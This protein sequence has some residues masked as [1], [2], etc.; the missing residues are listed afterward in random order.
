MGLPEDEAAAH[1]SGAVPLRSGG[2]SSHGGLGRV[3]RL[4]VV[5]FWTVLR[6][7][8]DELVVIRSVRWRCGRR[9]AAGPAWHLGLRLDA[10]R[11]PVA[12]LV[13][14]LKRKC[15]LLTQSTRT[16]LRG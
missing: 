8:K 10:M 15:R 3:G 6:A 7:A 9:L 5:Q 11:S 13:G 4:S 14:R 12:V 1:G 2:S 16:G